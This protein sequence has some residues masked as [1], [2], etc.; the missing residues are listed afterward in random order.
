M[1]ARVYEIQLTLPTHQPI[2]ASRLAPI[3]DRGKA[4][5]YPY[6]TFIAPSEKPQTQTYRMWAIENERRLGLTW[7]IRLSLGDGEEFLTQETFL[8]N[9]SPRAAKWHLWSNAAVDGLMDTEFVYPPGKIIV[10]GSKNEFD[11]WPLKWSRIGE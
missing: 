8:H 5:L 7:V 3:F 4:P 10:H 1:P 6:T 11:R 2:L 9:P